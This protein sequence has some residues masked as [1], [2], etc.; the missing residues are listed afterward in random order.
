MGNNKENW[1]F[2][3]ADLYT[4]PNILTY[5]RFLL[6]APFAYFF[7]NENYLPAALCVGFSGL[8]DCLDGFVA[9]KFNQVTS[10]GKILD[11][12]ADKLTLLVVVVCMVVYVPVVLPVLIVLLL[13]DVAMLAGGTDLI[14]KGLTPP[15][16]KWYGKVGTI[17]FYISVCIIVFIKAVFSKD[18]YALDFI[19]LS[20]TAVSMLF[21][22]YKYGIIYFQM[23]KEY[24]Q[25][26]SN[27]NSVKK[28]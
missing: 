12:I 19:L 1:N 11:P 20:L 2:K 4:I 23:I 26:Q 5:I 24:K 10:L 13:K 27:V 28:Q 6:I 15:A 21:A 17:L 8:S 22:L 9:R 7:L 25:K 16:A 18:Y 3:T 14:K